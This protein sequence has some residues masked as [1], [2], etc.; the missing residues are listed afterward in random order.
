[1]TWTPKEL[2]IAIG[3]KREKEKSTYEAF[4]YV[5][6]FGIQVAFAGKDIK[7]FEEKKDDNHIGTEEKKEELKRLYESFEEVK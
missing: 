1:M 7:L 4:K 6:A 3:G 2:R 5:I